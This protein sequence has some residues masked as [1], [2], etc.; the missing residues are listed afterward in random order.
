V[1]GRVA[2]DTN[3]VIRYFKGEPSVV[4]RFKNVFPC[5]PLPVVGELMFAV[6][7][8]QHKLTNLHKLKGF[9]E[10]CEVLP[11]GV[12]SAQQ[13]AGVRMDLKRR[14][15]PIPENDVWIAAS[16]LEHKLPLAT[17]DGHFEVVEDLKILKW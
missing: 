11:M 4:A 8:S 15:Q 10:A 9:L 7:N 13:Y 12:S 1:S 5:L 2:L 6:E 3:V 17:Y 14:G 16:C